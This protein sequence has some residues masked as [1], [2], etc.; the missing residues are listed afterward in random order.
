VLKQLSKFDYGTEKV[1]SDVFF[2][3][4]EDNYIVFGAKEEL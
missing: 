1:K 3:V 2:N 4:L